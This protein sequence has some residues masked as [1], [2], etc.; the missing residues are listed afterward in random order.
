MLSIIIFLLSNN[1]FSSIRIKIKQ[2]N[3]GNVI[4]NYPWHSLRL[5]NLPGNSVFMLPHWSNV[6]SIEFENAGYRRNSDSKPN[7]SQ[8]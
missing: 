2:S 1:C 8:G 5:S 7:G 3:I 4:L 6:G